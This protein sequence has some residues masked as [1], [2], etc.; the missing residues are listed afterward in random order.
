MSR[1]SQ[2]VN[3]AF[4]A[5]TAKEDCGCGSKTVPV[6]TSE[7]ISKEAR[8]C[9]P[10]ADRLI[11]M[12]ARKITYS[13]PQHVI[14]AWLTE[15]EHCSGHQAYLIYTAAQLLSQAETEH[16]DQME[17]GSGVESSDVETN[18]TREQVLAAIDE[19]G[20]GLDYPFGTIVGGAASEATQPRPQWGAGGMAVAIRSLDR[21]IEELVTTGN[22][23]GWTARRVDHLAAV[24]RTLEAIQRDTRAFQTNEKTLLDQAYSHDGYTS[25]QAGHDFFLSRNGHG[26]GFFD[27]DLGTVGDQL[28]AATKKYGPFDLYYGDD[29]KLYASGHENRANEE[30]LT[31]TQRNDLPAS[32]FALPET[33]QLPIENASHV[34]PAASRLVMMWNRGELSKTQY[35]EAHRR[36]VAAG[37][38]YGVHVKEDFTV[39][40]PVP[41]R[42]LEAAYEERGLVWDQN[43]KGIYSAGGNG[44]TYYLVPQVSGNYQAVWMGRDGNQKDLGTMALAS[45]MQVAARF[46]PASGQQRVAAEGVAEDPAAGHAQIQRMVTFYVQKEGLGEYVPNSAMPTGQKNADGSGILSFY[47]RF[48]GGSAQKREI[49]SDYLRQVYR[50]RG[51]NAPQVARE[52]TTPALENINPTV[53]GP[54]VRLEKDVPRF[55][56]CQKLAEKIGPI[57]GHDTLHAFIRPQM[58]REDVEVFFAVIVDTQMMARGYTEIARGSRD[59]VMTPVPDTT[60]F[61]L[62]YAQHYGAM[63]L[64]IAHTHP[65]GSARK[66]K[67]DDEVTES[68]KEA[69]RANHICFLDHLV[70]GTRQYYS[71][72][73]EK[74]FKVK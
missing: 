12:T 50:N 8:D 67:A 55:E 36:I 2:R 71:Y 18:A 1:R 23:R 25:E 59:S 40:E 28:Q 46:D 38:R 10:H 39:G 37:K 72:R 17:N 42:K 41:F 26:A 29:G 53:C 27:R 34:I 30:R 66:S 60:R 6:V 31:T 19:L 9:M 65:S 32:A 20:A 47:T 5:P 69:C 7:T 13:E 33:R 68:I 44:G 15:Q 57:T 61:A 4:E 49:S 48:N 11:R 45:A 43:T 58:E 73:A 14:Y 64:G 56:A 63:G 51:A 21:T 74:I 24:R 62:A 70:I 3:A 16:L 54:W 35:G 52:A 22:E